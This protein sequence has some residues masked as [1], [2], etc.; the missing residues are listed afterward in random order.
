MKGFLAFLRGAGLEPVQAGQGRLEAGLG[1]EG[2]SLGAG[3]GPGLGWLTTR[4]HYNTKTD[5][6]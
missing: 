1:T 3:L 4:D 2:A 5:I 6:S